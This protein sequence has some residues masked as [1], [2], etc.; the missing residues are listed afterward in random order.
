MVKIYYGSIQKWNLILDFT[1][2]DNLNIKRTRNSSLERHMQSIKEHDGQPHIPWN[3]TDVLLHTA[4]ALHALTEKLS[5]L[6]ATPNFAINKCSESQQNVVTK[7]NS[8]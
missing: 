1:I 4:A 3:I 5:I 8:S 6:T 7:P 2:T